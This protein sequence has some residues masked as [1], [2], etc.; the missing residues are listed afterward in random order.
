MGKIKDTQI[1]SNIK[2]PVDQKRTLVAL[3]LHRIGQVV[4]HDDTDTIKGM[5]TKVK[6][7]VSVQN[8]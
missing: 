8:A 6:H 4:E 7:L 2:R 1:K 3:G 5:I